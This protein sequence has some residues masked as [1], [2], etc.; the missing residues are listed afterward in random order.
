MKNPLILMS[1]ITG[2][3]NRK[4][5]F[6][7]LKGL[8]E[9]G[10]KQVLL[11][12]RSGCEI[13]YLSKDWFDTIRC[14]LE[15][16]KELDMSIWLYDDFNWPSGD[17]GGKV[18][19][20][21][22]YRLKA[23]KVCGKDKCEISYKSKHNSGLFGEK[24]FPNL[25]SYECVDYFI[26]CTHE[27]YFNHFEEYFGNVIT[28]IFTDEPSIGYSC[29]GDSIPYYD[30][31]EKDYFDTYG[32]DFY[33]DLDDEFFHKNAIS[34][35]SK[36]FK[37]CYIDAL[38]LWCKSHNILMTGHLMCDND[39]F[40]AVKHGGRFL[41]NLSG[42]S[43]PGIDEIA[44]CFEDSSLMTLLGSIEYAS[45]ENGAMAELFALGPISMPYAKKRSMLYLCACHKVSHY[46][47]AI[48]H[49]DM[50]GN[51][52]ICDYFNN[53]NVDQPDFKGMKLLAKD[54]EIATKLS[55]KDFEPD[56]YIRYP[57]DLSAKNIT[58]GLDY[59]PLHKLLTS[60]SYNQIQWKLIDTEDAGNIPLIEADERLSFTLNGEP[61][62]ISKIPRKV[63]VTDQNGD[64]PQGIFVRRFKDDSYVIINLT[65]SEGEYFVNG[66]ATYIHKNDVIFGNTAF[67]TLNKEGMVADFRINYCND[68]IARAMHINDKQVSEIYCDIKLPVKLYVRND[69]EAWLNNEEISCF[70]CDEGLPQGMRDLY[71]MC[72][73]VWLNEGKN[74]IKTSKDFKY[75]PSILL[76]GDFNC[77]IQDDKD[78]CLNLSKRKANYTV[79]EKFKDYGK[80]ELCANVTVPMDAC[81]IELTG[82]ELYTEIY[83]NNSL[84]GNAICPPYNFALDKSLKGKVITIKIVQY[85][86]LSPIFGNVDYWDKNS[87]ASQW[88]GTPSSHP[89]EF[90]F[91][92]INWIK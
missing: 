23:I 9:N 76:S 35:I 20:I 74:Q 40:G 15:I 47:L 69:T 56:V 70:S 87:V 13:E 28:G 86:S 38:R 80:I 81:G 91:K 10:I 36:R 24:F 21:P 88:R 17:C 73:D 62:D 27:E 50:R 43:L 37:C 75:L 26:K 5:I 85:S 7:Y 33:E 32:R 1:A 54:A 90:G 42:F 29:Q 68:N 4:R 72:P 8:N 6:E 84:T 59:T 52:L 65:S 45:N 31:L 41:E 58:R 16:A 57:F 2:K 55:K 18:T 64:T 63:V 71:K 11:Y 30:G 92:K 19:K 14:F 49:L 39:P 78:Y 83:I 51:R 46:F 12:P 48:S 61:L 89:T 44:T 34:L 79:G 82:T 66:K 25:L 67:T 60:L 77:E 22:E 53:F 3:P